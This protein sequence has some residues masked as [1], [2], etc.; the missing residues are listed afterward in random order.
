M[1]LLVYLGKWQDDTDENAVSLENL[2]RSLL[3]LSADRIKDH[4]KDVTFTV[5][6][7]TSHFHSG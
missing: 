5:P 6:K 1:A 7:G 4:I 2:E 3:R